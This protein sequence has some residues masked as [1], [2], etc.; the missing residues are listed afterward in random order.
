M[1]WIVRITTGKAAAR[2]F[3]ETMKKAAQKR[4]MAAYRDINRLRKR[5]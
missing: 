3:K 2:D 5:K 1:D 4:A